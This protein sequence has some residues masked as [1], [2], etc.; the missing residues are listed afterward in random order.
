MVPSL[1]Q[2]FQLVLEVTVIGGTKSS[3]DLDWSRSDV[4]ASFQMSADDKSG[5]KLLAKPRFVYGY[6]RFPA[7]SA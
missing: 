7:G 2:A 5:H 4:F 6:Q 1:H 3:I